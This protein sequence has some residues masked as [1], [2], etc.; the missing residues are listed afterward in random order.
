MGFA[1]WCS[2]GVGGVTSRGQVAIL[3]GGLACEAAAVGPVFRVGRSDGSVAD[4]VARVGAGTGLTLTE[5]RSSAMIS[6]ISSSVSRQAV[7]L[8]IATTPTWCLPTRS[9]SDTLAS[10]RRFCGGWGKI[11][12]WSRRL[13]LAV[14]HGDLAAGPEAGV[15]R[16]DDLLGD[17][18]LEQQAAPGCGRRPRQRASRRSRSGRGGPRARC[19]A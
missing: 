14:E 4:S 16:Q 2:T 6:A 3:M 1:E 8:P 5:S 12:V 19:W 7:P 15:D 10:D 9:L 13:P 17:R 11:T 18:R